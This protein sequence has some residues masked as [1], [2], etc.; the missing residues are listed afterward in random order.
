M[1]FDSS[2]PIWAQ[3]AAEFR[4]RIA[5]GEWRSGERVPGVRELAVQL[6]V[7]PNTVQRTFS[8]LEHEGLVFAE[9]TA[10]RFVTDDSA[11]VTRL[12]RG[13]AAAAADAYVD[14]ASGLSLDIT[15]ATELLHERWNRDD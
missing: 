6:G 4:R 11:A 12:K 15:A 3:L 5:V 1:K 2:Q 9:R 8:E 14:A 13:L 10:G 7:N